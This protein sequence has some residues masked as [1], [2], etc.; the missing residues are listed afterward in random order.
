[1]FKKVILACMIA[2]PTALA[3]AEAST[4]GAAAPEDHNNNNCGYYDYNPQ[5]CNNLW[6]CRFDYYSNRCEHISGPQPRECWRFD[7]D[8]YACNQQPNCRYDDWARRCVDDSNPGPGQCYRF[9]HDPYTCE[10]QPECFWDDWSRTC[11]DQTGPGPGPGP[12]H[13]YT[14]DL[15]CSSNGYHYRDC[16]VNGQV[17]TVFLERQFSQA[18]CVQGQSWGKSPRGVWVDRGCSASFRVTYYP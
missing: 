2:A 1:M 13:P 12:G 11:R 17:V 5:G 9:S 14:I 3:F 16:P 7:R 4:D 6:Y 10:Q 15:T 18:P 8:P